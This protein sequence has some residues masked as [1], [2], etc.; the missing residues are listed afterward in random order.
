MPETPLP[1]LEGTA[2]VGLLAALGL[3]DVV[4]R[5]RPE[6]A[7]RLSWTDDV[8]PR[9]VLHSKV[10]LRVDG[11]MALVLADRERWGRSAALLP[12]PAD[13]STPADVKLSPSDLRAWALQVSDAASNEDRA[14]AALQLGLVSEGALADTGEAKPSHLHF[15]AGQ[16]RFLEAARDLA[17]DADES[18][19]RDALVGPWSYSSRLKG[20]NWD[21]RG[22]RVYAV[23]GSDPASDPKFT[24]PGVNWLALLGLASFPV[25]TR[26]GRALTTGASPA[27]KTGTFT[28]P[29]W[30]APASLPVARS[31]VARADLA[32]LEQDQLALLGVH[33]VLRAPISRS[34]QG[35][36]GSFGPPS[37]V[38]RLRPST[39][40]RAS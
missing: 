33:R 1:G 13:G 9:A 8:V 4:T 12:R 10:D 24:A 31:L 17:E 21:P 15:L 23:S 36:Y 16:Q 2:P 25:T 14:D 22:A 27:W 38:A 7:P 34:D 5:T 35:G 26:R 40:R 6:D 30:L 11:L 37:E 29:L 18:H 39:R 32:D 20:F 28:W 3:L 19:L